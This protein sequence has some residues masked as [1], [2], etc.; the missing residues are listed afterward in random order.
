MEISQEAKAFIDKLD[1]DNHRVKI[2]LQALGL[3]HVGDTFVGNADVRGVSGGQRRRVSIGE[4]CQTVSPVLCGDEISTGLDAAA[5]FDICRSLMFFGQVNGM[6]RILSLLQPSP[7]TVSLFDEVI[8]MADGKILYAGPISEVEGYFETLGYQPPDQMDIAD[9]LQEISTP[10][11][12]SLYKAE[13]DMN[14]LG[15]PYSMSE[16]ADQFRLSVYYQKIEHE[17]AEPWELSWVD[18]KAPLV[19][20]VIKKYR[21]SF[22]RATFLNLSRT[23]LVWSRDRRFLVA[24]AIK[25]IIMGVSVGGV[26]YQTDNYV[27]IFGVCFQIN[28]FI[29]LGKAR[30]C[31]NCLV[32][33][34]L[35]MFF[36]LELGAM[37]AAPGEVDD[38]IIYYKHHDS[39]FYGVLPYVIGK[40]VGLMPQV[41]FLRLSK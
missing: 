39:N 6:V 18:G 9:F 20:N 4:M 35:L 14:G 16:L 3:T 34:P 32:A 26:F 25:N 5:T 22:P 11:P 31:A 27:S 7:E 29:M 21:N 24:N 28:L 8:L 12:N 36:P 17:Q 2:L 38:R 19:G 33:C 23:L 40:A 37:V 10:G 13:F 41:S 1:N 15:K 30:S